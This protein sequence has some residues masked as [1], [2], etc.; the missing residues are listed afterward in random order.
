MNEL[1]ADHS[2]LEF[3]VANFIMRKDLALIY[4]PDEI[5]IGTIRRDF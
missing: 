1:K 2:R 4:S 3:M 5:A